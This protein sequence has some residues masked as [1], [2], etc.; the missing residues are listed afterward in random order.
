M[1]G[2]WRCDTNN[3][4]ATIYATPF[5]DWTG[6]GQELR[7]G[8]QQYLQTKYGYKGDVLCSMATPG[9]NTLD[10][11][12]ADMQRQYAQF[13]AQGKTVVEVPWTITVARRHPR[14]RLFRP[15]PGESRQ[16]VQ[17]VQQGLPG[18]GGGLG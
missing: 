4:P 12:Q 18:S 8:F 5:M 10:K 3:G 14:V 6:F 16:R 9:P 13:R 1:K 2:Y 17:P 11:L 15:G 7:N